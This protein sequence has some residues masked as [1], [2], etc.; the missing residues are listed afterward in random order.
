MSRLSCAS[1]SGP[2]LAGKNEPPMTARVSETMAMAE[3]ACSSF[4]VKATV[5]S[6]MPVAASAAES[7]SA[8][9]ADGIAPGRPQ[10]QPGAED[11]HA[12]RDERQDHRDDE[13]AGQD[14]PPAQGRR[15]HARERP[16][17]PLRVDADD[18]ELGREEDEEDGHGGRV[19]GGVAGLAVGD[20][21]IDERDGIGDG[22]G[23][24]GQRGRGLGIREAAIGDERRRDRQPDRVDLAG[25][26]VEHR[27]R[28]LAADDRVGIDQQLDRA[29]APGHGCG[30]EAV[31]HDD[32]RLDL[33]GSIAARAA[34]ASA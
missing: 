23:R 34:S 5:S 13:L 2:W 9:S 12:H 1:S 14:R 17:A 33:T 3:P 32:G 22:G 25:E 27:A 19:V 21:D 26:A 6:E 24:L 18:P 29:A 30:T 11:D 7:T 31:G 20:R 10:Q 28:H 16:V 4:L 8:T 15:E